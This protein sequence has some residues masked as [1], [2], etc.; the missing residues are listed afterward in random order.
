MDYPQTGIKSS[1]QHDVLFLDLFTCC[2]MT[3]AV[4]IQNPTL[5][6]RMIFFFMKGVIALWQCLNYTLTFIL[7]EKKLDAQASQLLFF[8]FEMV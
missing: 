4:L 6:Y 1:F 2:E 5:Y 7:C 3:P 8:L